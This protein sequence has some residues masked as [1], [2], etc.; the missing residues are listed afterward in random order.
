MKNLLIISCLFFSYNTI[1]QKTVV[2]QNA[3]ELAVAMDDGSFVGTSDIG[4]TIRIS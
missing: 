2:V 4:A 3:H 1:A